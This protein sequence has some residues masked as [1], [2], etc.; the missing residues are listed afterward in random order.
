MMERRGRNEIEEGNTFY[1]IA[2]I[3]ATMIAAI[4]WIL[5]NCFE[6]ALLRFFGANDALIFEYAKKYTFWMKI[7]LPV[8]LLGQFFTCFI[9]NDNAPMRA[10]LAVIGGGITNIIL[11]VSLVFGCQMGISGAGLATMIG[12]LVSFG[13]LCTHF[14]SKRRQ[15][16][17]T[18][19]CHFKRYFLQIIK[20]GIPSFILDIAMG[21]LVILFNNQIVA[22]N[23]GAQQTA[24]LAI[25]GVVCNIVALVQSLGYAVGQAS[26]PLLSENFGANQIHRVKKF[27]KYGMI[28][29]ALISI[30]AVL[31]LELFPTEILHIFLKVEEGS[32][33]L[34]LC[35]SIERIYFLSFIFLGFNVF[36]TYYFQ[37]ILK[38]HYA[39]LVSLLRGIVLSFSF[40][41]LLP[42]LFGFSA[43]WYTMLATESLV[44]LVN[45]LLVIHTCRNLDC[46]NTNIE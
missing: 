37:S 17:L 23:D 15:I 30:L 25:Y 41:F 45:L 34:E 43:I 22:Y 31:I 2:F 42:F 4:L 26:Q 7:S 32:L 27:L 33:V 24:I 14:I 28:S 9:R 18:R 36:S 13:I 16:R 20:V 21:A 35:N 8:F 5:I 38:A 40:L 3:S 46:K 10:T 39:F 29:S 11:D 1:T 12:Q 19:I 6:N 44:F